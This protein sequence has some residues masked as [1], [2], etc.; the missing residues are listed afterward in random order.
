MQN[1]GVSKLFRNK[2]LVIYCPIFEVRVLFNMNKI[3]FYMPNIQYIYYKIH[4]II[5]TMDN[6]KLIMNT[7]TNNSQE[8]QSQEKLGPFEY[9]LND[10]LLFILKNLKRIIVDDKIRRH[11]IKGGEDA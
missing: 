5:L 10:S 11:L 2:K 9:K 7:N 8:K 4:L 3:I 6:A 1:K